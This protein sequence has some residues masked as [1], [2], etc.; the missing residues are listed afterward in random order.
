MRWIL[1]ACTLIYIVKLKLF[2][3]FISLIQHPLVI[4][5]SVFE[6]VITKGMLNNYSD[7]FEAEKLLQRFKIPVISID[8]SQDFHFFRDVGETSCFILAK[9]GGIYITSDD[10]TYKKMFKLGQKVIR[11]DS[12]YFQNYLD[13][14][15]K[16]D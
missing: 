2:E 10:K 9:D 16:E 6:E 3:N 14:K 12:F 11:L 8:I 7:A 15:L 4:D 5:S 13:K 1:D